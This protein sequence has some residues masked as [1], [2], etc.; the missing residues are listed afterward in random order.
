VGAS[1]SKSNNLL[2]NTFSQ[3]VYDEFLAYKKEKKNQKHEKKL[4]KHH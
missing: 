2:R 4:I 3:E 1:A